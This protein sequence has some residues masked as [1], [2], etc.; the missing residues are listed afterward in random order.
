[1]WHI[2]ILLSYLERISISFFTVMNSS[3]RKI[4]ACILLIM[5][6]INFSTAIAGTVNRCASQAG[7]CCGGIQVSGH[8][9]S[10]AV[11]F[12][13]QGCCSSSA[14]IPC[15]LNENYMPD[16]QVFIVSSVRENLREA[17]GL[18]TFVIGEPSFFQTFRDNG[19][20]NQFWITNDPIPIYLQNLT[21]IC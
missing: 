5:L 10:P 13:G 16:S 7:C 9:S 21:L 3:H 11:D 12:A 2:I 1:M 19:T 14:N 15:N 6:G 18:I 17:E 20:T 4:V 8:E